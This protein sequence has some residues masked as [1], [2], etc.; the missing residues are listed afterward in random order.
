MGMKKDISTSFAYPM[1]LEV[2]ATYPALQAAISQ[3]VL[4]GVTNKAN[5]P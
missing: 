2:L 3:I 5:Y 4:A 1:R